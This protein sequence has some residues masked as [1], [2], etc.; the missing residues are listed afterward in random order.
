V[1]NKLRSYERTTGGNFFLIIAGNPNMED[2]F[3]AIP[4]DKVKHLFTNDLIHET[5]RNAGGVIERWLIRVKQSN[6]GSYTM[7][8]TKNEL[9]ASHDVTSWYGDRNAIGM[10]V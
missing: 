4:W 3:F 7:E 1:R 9:K 5:P 2:D 8:V 10:N 6:T